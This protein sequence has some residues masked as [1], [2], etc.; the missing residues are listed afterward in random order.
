MI[1]RRRLQVLGGVSGAV[2]PMVARAQQPGKVWRIG[3]L[4]ATS[5]A[6]VTEH[7][8][9]LRQSP[10]EL[11]DVPERGLASVGWGLCAPD[12]FPHHHGAT[13]TITL[14]D[15]RQFADHGDVP[16]GLPPRN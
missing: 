15:G 9:T 13:V 11:G 7:V 4:H 3:V 8:T 10:A 16:R 1:S 14:K 6:S 5:P 2:A 12:R